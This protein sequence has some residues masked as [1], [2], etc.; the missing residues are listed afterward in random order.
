M[1]RTFFS[2]LLLAVGAMFFIA[3]WGLSPMARWIPLLVAAPTVLLLIF[4]LQRDFAST[5]TERS[6]TGMEI[7]SLLWL[8]VLPGLIYVIGFLLA[9]PLYLLAF[10]I[11][12]AREPWARALVVAIL[13]AIS[14]LALKVFLNIQLYGGLLW[15]YL[16]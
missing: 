9:V 1:S 2:G 12:W 6:N 8:M 15:D 3:L 11:W 5:K 13:F 4:Q 7:R 14:L 16:V 10:G